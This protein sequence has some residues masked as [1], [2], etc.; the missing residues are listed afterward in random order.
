MI[1]WHPLLAIHVTEQYLAPQIP[2]AHR[3]SPTSPSR[4]ADYIQ[5]LG[6]INRVFPQ[7]VRETRVDK[8]LLR[9]ADAGKLFVGL[10]IVG[11]AT[12]LRF[13]GANAD[14]VWSRLHAELG[15]TNPRYVGSEPLPSFLPERLPLQRL[16]GE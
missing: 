16:H 11:D 13:E 8:T 12:K 3:T 7:P 5:N 1:L 15:K 4:N 6:S 10:A 14:E 9:L 2:T